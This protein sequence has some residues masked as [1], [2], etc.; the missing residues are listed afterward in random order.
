[1]QTGS[2]VRLVP[3]WNSSAQARSKQMTFSKN[4]RQHQTKENPRAAGLLSRKWQM[5]SSI[6]KHIDRY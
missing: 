6:S 5:R 3:L 2:R 1:M 4:Q